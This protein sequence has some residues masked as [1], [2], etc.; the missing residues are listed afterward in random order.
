M[1]YKASKHE[2]LM[3]YSTTALSQGGLVYLMMG[4][5][6]EER[7]RSPVVLYRIPAMMSR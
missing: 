5:T 4:G 2:S 6:E 7:K 1:N 3:D